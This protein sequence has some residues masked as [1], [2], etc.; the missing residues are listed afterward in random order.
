MGY[1]FPVTRTTA[2]KQKPDQKALGFG[3]YYTDHMFIM[4]YDEGEGWHDGKIV[5]YGP[6]PLDPAACTLHYAQMT[7]EGM[8]AYRN[9]EGGVI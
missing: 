7:F 4:E 2:P 6:L 1:E 9:P 3:K 8:K 5:P